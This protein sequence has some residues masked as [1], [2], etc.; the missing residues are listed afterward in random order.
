M[1]SNEFPSNSQAT[2]RQ[3]TGPKKPDEKVVEKIVTGSVVQRKK[4]LGKRFTETFFGGGH[5]TKDVG[6]YVFFDVMIPAA[7]DMVVDSVIQ[8]AERS[9]FGEV[10]SAGRRGGRRGGRIDYN[11]ISRSRSPLFDREERERGLSRRSRA[12][13]DF[14][15][16]VLESRAE[17]IEV[18]QQMYDYLAKYEQVTVGDLYGLVGI[19]AQFTDDRWGWVDLR[20]A[21]V[22]RVRDGYLLDLPRPVALD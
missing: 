11:G 5:S 14:D 9:M 8:F 16:I 7:K 4:S 22:V 6:A 13:H 10:R 2:R 20:G 3:D 19:T 17:G 18:I 1:E 21:D 15:E 12:T